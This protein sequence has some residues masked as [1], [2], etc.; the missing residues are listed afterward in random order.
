MDRSPIIDTHVHFFNMRNPDPGMAWVWLAADFDHPIIGDIDGMKHL[1]YDIR[2]VWAEARFADVGGF[3]HVQAAL[4]STDVIQETRWL[5]RMREDSPVPFT[6]IGD[7][8]L[9]S[10]EAIAQL[11]AHGESPYFV[12]I[13]DF[14]AEPMLASGEVDAAYEASLD[15]MAD[16]GLVFDLDCEWMNMAAARRLADRHPDLQ[17]VLEHLGFPRSRDDEYFGHWASALEDL[18]G[19]PNVTCKI[20]GVGM[21]DPMFTPESLR[22]WI[23]MPLE[24]FGADR[25]VLGSNWPVDRLYSSYDAIMNIYRDRIAQVVGKSDEH[26]VLSDN[27]ARIYRVVPD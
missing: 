22:R 4:G 20:S 25:C 7:A 10:D 3:V 12:G 21:T 5:T 23:D 26:K 13:R 19:A 17:I 18:A 15:V 16:R 9:G 8:D 2:H 11:D 6:I 14:K 1:T 24:L 27:A